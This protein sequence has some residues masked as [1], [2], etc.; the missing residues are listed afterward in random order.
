M[1]NAV[2]GEAELPNGR[3]LRF[4]FNA[5]CDLE[6]KIGKP[7]SALDWDALSMSD[8][9]ALL[10]AGMKSAD[11]AITV[12]Q[13]GDVVQEVGLAPTMA[14]LGA[15][16]SAAFPAPGASEGNGTGPGQ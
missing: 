5:L 16:F 3:I 13:A 11:P 2:R 8:L 7:V 9:R 14:A 12:E 1:V 6:A 10:W 15:A 4:T